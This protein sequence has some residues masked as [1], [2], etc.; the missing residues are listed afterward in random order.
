MLVEDG[1]MV[2]IRNV[3]PIGTNVGQRIGTVWGIA[4]IGAISHLALAFVNNWHNTDRSWQQRL[5]PAIPQTEWIAMKGATNVEM[6]CKIGRTWPSNY[7]IKNPNNKVIWCSN[8]CTC[9]CYFEQEGM[10]ECMSMLGNKLGNK[11]IFLQNAILAIC[12]EIRECWQK[13]RLE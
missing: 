8:C 10:R 12:W 1:L 4:R 7:W 2:W 6:W 9:W 13:L 3:V 5:L 11:A